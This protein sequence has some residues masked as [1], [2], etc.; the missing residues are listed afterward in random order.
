MVLLTTVIHWLTTVIHWSTT[1]QVRYTS[2][3]DQQPLL[4][5]SPVTKP[6]MPWYTETR[7]DT[8]RTPK[9]FIPIKYNSQMDRVNV[10]RR[11]YLWSKKLAIK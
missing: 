6:V 7:A 1:V 4:T 10:R 11:V 9:S 3:H 5:A 8:I 2:C